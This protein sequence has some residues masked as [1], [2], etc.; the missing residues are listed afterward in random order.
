MP[1]IR[2]RVTDRG[3]IAFET[4]PESGT[5]NKGL[6][7]DLKSGGVLSANVTLRSDQAGS[8]VVS[9]SA[10]ITVTMPAAS[11]VQGTLWSFR[12]GS[13]H[14]HVIISGSSETVIRP[15]TDGTDNGGS[16]ATENVVGSSMA[17]MC[18][19]A[20]FLILGSSGSLTLA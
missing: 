16:V 6:G 15:F 20:S 3:I 11:E 7:P 13:N 5:R 10:V 17:I 18:D 8:Y 19:G 12:A 14:A 9:G 4:S 2:H 1:R